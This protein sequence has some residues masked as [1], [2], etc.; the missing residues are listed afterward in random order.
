[1]GKRI[2]VTGAAG[3]IGFH[4]SKALK[5]RGDFVIGYDN[6]N[7]YYSPLLKN[8][9]AERLRKIGVEVLHGDLCNS[10]L[11]TETVDNFRITHIAHLAAQA[12]VRYSLENPQAYVQS[13]IEGFVNILE[14]C[15]SN[16]GIKLTYASSS[17]VYGLNQKVPF[18]EQDPTD[19]QASLYGATKKSNELFAASYHHLFKIAA[20]GIRYFTVYGPWG[21]PDMA[22][23]TFT[24]AILSGKPIQIFNYGRMKRD[25]TYIDDAVAG[26][27]A[28]IDLGADFEIFNLGNNKPVE[29]MEFIKVIEKAT[30]RSARF[31][32]L[33][34]Q[35]GDVPATYADISHSQEK[36]NFSPST[37]LEEGIPKFVKWFQEQKTA[38]EVF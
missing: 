26:T 28:A 14:V 27:I 20:T 13:N 21:R 6:F 29:L 36:L 11:L 9:R 19:L 34:M 8:A 5:E 32:Y 22:Y 38:I 35:Q 12:G 4:L 10:P 37:S 2:L 24:D 7:D 33:P 17:S 18:S 1:M 3:F 23:Y 16:P 15:R 30:G 25:F 31:E